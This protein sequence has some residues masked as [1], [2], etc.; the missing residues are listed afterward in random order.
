[1]TELILTVL[2]A[3]HDNR[4][5]KIVSEITFPEKVRGEII[6]SSDKKD[7]VPPEGGALLVITDS[8]DI[9]HNAAEVKEDNIHIVYVGTYED[10]SDIYEKL[11][12]VW[13][14]TGN[15]TLFKDRL[16]SYVQKLGDGF[17]LCFYQNALITTIN[18]VPDMLWYKR[19]D[20][21]HMLVND[22]FTEIV[23]KPKSDIHGRD[24]FYIWDAP[25]PDGSWEKIEHLGN[26]V[27]GNDVE[28][29]ANTTVD[30]AQMESTIIQRIKH[31]Y[32]TNSGT[33]SE[34]S[35]WD[36]TLP[37]SAISEL[38]FRYL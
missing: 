21:I 10:V 28:I 32:M 14:G 37:I 33:F 31:P 6:N 22:A 16:N 5:S 18:T 1:M 23:H 24:H 34:Q 7:F 29:G 35:A 27:I 15:S 20:G 25:R 4:Y 9:A 8:V 2:N 30:R 12:E 11:D 13:D 38:S 19:L 26:V 3:C 36:M 17:A